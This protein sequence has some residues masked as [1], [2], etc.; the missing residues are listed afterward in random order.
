MVPCLTMLGLD[1]ARSDPRVYAAIE[2]SGIPFW[3]ISRTWRNEIEKRQ[4]GYQAC[5]HRYIYRID[6]DEI[7][8]F[9]DRALET[10]LSRGLAIGGMEMPTYIAPGWISCPRDEPGIGRQCFLFDR[11]RISPE[12]HLNYLWLVL[13]ADTLPLA[14]TRPFDVY[15]DPLAFNAH[16]T[17]WRTPQ[18]SVSRAAFYVLNWMRQ[19][20][21][22]WLPAL[23]D[24][25]L[26][27]LQDLFDIVPPDV[28]YSSL[29]MGPIALG[30]TETIEQ[31]VLRPTTL[32]AGQETVFAGLYQNFLAKL[33]E[34]N[35]Q[36]AMTERCFLTC[37]PVLMDL[38]THAARDAIAPNGSARFGISAP[39]LSA[40]V[41]LLTYA[42]GEPTIEVQVLPASLRGRE[43]HVLLPDPP[44][45]ERRV[46]RQC[47]EFQVWPDSQLLPQRFRVLP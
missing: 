43:L 40:S 4:A 31:R 42:T 30:M 39:L 18:T 10:A 24:R 12:I 2:A 29:R 34:M 33:A 15:P 17:G 5:L 8:F 41:R 19:Y 38:S 14:G 13:T 35:A 7:L 44:A 16:L 45:G 9:D 32:G 3:V 22:P 23:R 28:F 1:P 27:N 46:L 11:Q 25:P 20:G 21:V 26:G 37:L 6:A 47:L 36:P